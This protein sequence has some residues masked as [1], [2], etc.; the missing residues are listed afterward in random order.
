MYKKLLLIP[1][2][3]LNG[4][5]IIDLISDLFKES[6]TYYLLSLSILG[7]G[8][9]VYPFDFK[10][11]YNIDYIFLTVKAVAFFNLL[12]LFFFQDFSLK[13]NSINILTG[14]FAILLLL[15]RKK[16]KRR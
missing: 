4:I 8:I 16:N 2:L 15:L 3:V 11:K 6:F 13:I 5:I 10:F 9:V 14:I 12:N 7:L 1:F